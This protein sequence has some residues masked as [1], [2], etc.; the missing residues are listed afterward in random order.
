MHI[1]FDV[2]LKTFGGE[3]LKPPESYKKDVLTLKDT[4]IEA[5]LASSP[6][7][8]GENKFKSYKLAQK[9]SQGGDVEL[10]VEEVSQIKEAV[11]KCWG[12]NVVGPAWAILD[13]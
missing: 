2:V 5:L 7:Q 4:A 12:T 6:E 11:G 1:N 8:T 9:V 13:G 3:A 10:T